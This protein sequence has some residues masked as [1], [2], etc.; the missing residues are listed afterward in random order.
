M[1]I[2]YTDAPSIEGLADV[3]P[4]VYLILDGH[5]TDYIVP[6]YEQH[7][8][9]VT[10]A[11]IVPRADI[12]FGVENGTIKLLAKPLNALPKHQ[13]WVDEDASVRYEEQDCVT[14]LLGELGARNLVV[15]RKALKAR[16]LEEAM[17]WAQRSMYGE[18]IPFGLAIG[19]A[20]HRL[21]G[22]LEFSMIIEEAALQ[23]NP[24]FSIRAEVENLLA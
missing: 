19:A 6:P 20:V 13:L 15:A 4:A 21:K 9:C 3:V 22:D 11:T 8:E 1:I 16:N 23:L 14:Q 5:A 10:Q 7:A 17:K 2:G 18:S 24:D 12:E